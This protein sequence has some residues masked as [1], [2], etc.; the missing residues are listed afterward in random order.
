MARREY[1]I[2]ESGMEQV[3]YKKYTKNHNYCGLTVMK[4][5]KEYC[6]MIH[7]SW[8]SGAREDFHC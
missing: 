3:L 8:N 4:I 2:R 5:K 6:D 1:G 7:E